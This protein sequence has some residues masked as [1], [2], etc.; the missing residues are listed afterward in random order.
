[1][2]AVGLF[3]A[4]DAAVKQRFSGLTVTDDRKAQRPVKVFFR[5]PE[6]E[7][8][9][10]Y[11]FITIEQVGLSHAREL[12]LSESYYYYDQHDTLPPSESLAYWP[13]EMDEAGLAATVVGPGYL[14]SDS[15]IPIYLT[16][17]VSTYCRSAIHDRQLVSKMIRYVVPFRRG[18]ILVDADGTARRFDLLGWTNSDLL[19]IET[20]YRKRIFRKV[21]TIQMTAEIP[22]SEL[23]AI[24][25]STQ[26]S[27][28]LQV[29]HD[30]FPFNPYPTISE[31]F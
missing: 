1:M 11:P 18:S 13:S 10:D 19:D 16:Y 26:V 7:T 29:P 22:Q 17:Q 8:E 14:R 9:K 23:E 27:K 24:Q 30:P 25:R 21:F 2:T 3:F 31:V 28:D 12:Q 15:F 5:Y 6:A 4:E 20:G